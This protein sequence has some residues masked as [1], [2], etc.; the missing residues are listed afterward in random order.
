[1]KRSSFS[2]L[3]LGCLAL[4]TPCLGQATGFT[5]IGQDIRSHTETEAEV[6]GA[7]RVRTAWLN[8]LDLDRGPTPSGQLLYPVPLSDPKGQVLTLADMRLR[9]D[10]SFYAPAAAVAV[11]VRVDAPDNLTLGSDATGIP[12]GSTTQAPVTLV[13]IKRAYGEVLTPVGIIAAGR[14]GSQ[15][16]LG[17][18]TNGGDCSDCDSGDAAD[19]IAFI[20]PF[21]GLI[22]AVAY[23]FSW[24]GPVTHQD[25]PARSIDLDPADDVTSISFAVLR[26]SD[27]RARERR[28]EAGKGTFEAGAY[29]SH[30]FQ[31][32]DVPTAYLP[33]TDTVSTTTSSAVMSRGYKA[34]AVDGW[35]RIVFPN[36]RLE[37]EAAYLTATVDQPSL[38]P[39]VLLNN[40]AESTQWGGALETEIGAPESS[41][42]FGVDA[43][44]ASGDP[45][46]GFGVRTGITDKPAQ[47]GDLDGPQASPPTDNRVDN[48]RFHPD[49]RVDRILFREII[50]TVTDAVYLRPHLRGTVGRIGPGKFTASLAGVA[51]W[52]LTAESTPGGKA[53]LGVELDPTVAYESRDGFG[54]ALDYAALFP[55]AGLDNPTL[56]LPAKPA[57]LIRARLVYA[58]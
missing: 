22:W 49:Y 16:G 27:E 37:L 50:G 12:A 13:R 20:T 28:A 40:P 15:F 18:L 7:L 38:V 45:A 47:P 48:F 54:A 35:M 29:F 33:T 51:S 41:F 9:T 36:V 42:G 5:D 3:A 14:M 26:Y 53:P 31:D 24:S 46:P 25:A 4:L 34:T 23:D 8:N 52:A 57:Q 39:G 32:K 55:M 30:R 2:A 58:F 11:K 56:N 6:H 10:L 44:I 21:G 17:M 1:M 19:R 43:G